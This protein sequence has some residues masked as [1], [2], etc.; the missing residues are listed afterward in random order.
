MELKIV[1]Y[2]DSSAAIGHCSRLDNGKRMRHLEAADLWIQQLVKSKRIEIRKING[3]C[4]PA[5]LF[6]K[7]LSREEIIVHK[8]R[9]GYR[10]FDIEVGLLVK[11][12]AEDGLSLVRV[13]VHLSRG[14]SYAGHGRIRPFYAEGAARVYAQHRIGGSYYFHL[15]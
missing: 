13:K 9:I 5:D 8:N 10:L 1:I 7:L 3:K 2:S 12:H 14:G 4:N 15:R 6:T 11:E